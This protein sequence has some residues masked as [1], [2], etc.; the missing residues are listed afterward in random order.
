MGGVRVSGSNVSSMLLDLRDQS[1][2]IK[3][4]RAEFFP[5]RVGSGEVVLEV[6]GEELAVTG[7]ELVG[8]MIQIRIEERWG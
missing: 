3:E 1:E 6:D 8:G 7:I 2:K 5:G 4:V